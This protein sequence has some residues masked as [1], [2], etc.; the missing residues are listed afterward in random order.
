[1][2]I[3]NAIEATITSNMPSGDI[4]NM[5]INL[6]GSPFLMNML[7]NL[8][9]NPQLA[10]I[11]EYFCNAVDAHAAAG[12]LEN[13]LVTL[14]TWDSPVY[15][16]QD[17]GIGMSAESI[18]EIY[19]QYGAS[20]K[21]KSNNQI[22]AFGL[23]CK[24]ALTITNQFTVISIKDGQKSVALVS[25][26]ESGVNSINIVSISE[27]TAGN[28]TIVKVPVNNVNGFNHEAESFFKYAAPGTVLVDGVDPAG[29]FEEK[30]S[31]DV[32]SGAEIYY[33]NKDRYEEYVVVMGNVPYKMSMTDMNTAIDDSA[34]FRI[35]QRM[36]LYLVADIGD[37]DLTPNREGLRYTDKTIEFIKTRASEVFVTLREK[38][39]AEVNKIEN[40][41]DC[42]EAVN[43]WAKYGFDLRWN[44]EDVVTYVSAGQGVKYLVRHP[45]GGQSLTENTTSVEVDRKAYLIYDLDAEN[46]KEV[47][48]SLLA[49][50]R[51]F[52]AGQMRFYVSNDPAIVDH[53][54]VKH[55]N[56]I[57][58]ITAEEVNEAAKE[59]R[60][61]E[62]ASRAKSAPAAGKVRYPVLTVATKELTMVPYDEIPADS[63]YVSSESFTSSRSRSLLDDVVASIA[64]RRENFT[65]SN[66]STLLAPFTLAEHVVFIP[67]TRSTHAFKNRVKTAYDLIDDIQPAL[68]TLIGLQETDEIIQENALDRD[69]DTYWFRNLNLDEP[70]RLATIEDDELREAI[71][72]ALNTR[73]KSDTM[74]SIEALRQSL[75]VFA[76][77]DMEIPSIPDSTITPRDFNED[78]PL[79]SRM[80]YRSEHL[81]E[82]IVLYINAKFAQKTAQLADSSAT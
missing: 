79:I 1:M 19:A 13:V 72:S 26:T 23:G 75:R 47:S 76:G 70:R 31:L 22:G 60:K 67:R 59:Q 39:Q 30:D 29:F 28:G 5:S 20:T 12:V 42:F 46:Y 61:V 64:S 17:F 82:D 27:T 34:V 71:S 7:T 10:V 74:K 32:P 66:L 49:F 11:R 14:P 65:G 45:D 2:I 35:I 78:Y 80:T 57:T 16:V 73:P 4:T 81:W 6:E 63:A 21:R 43:R 50:T 77:P 51:S 8:Y 68:V 3:E 9:N 52:D 40:R 69:V 55:N 37:V 36:S 44:G 58:L 41:G 54:W 56:K 38:A 24:S 15:V 25:K 48:R 18:R 33:S 53:D 62:R